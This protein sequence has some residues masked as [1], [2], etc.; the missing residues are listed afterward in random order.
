MI[1]IRGRVGD[2]PVDLEIELEAQDWMHLGAAWTSTTPDSASGPSVPEES[3]RAPARGS[4][5]LW[6]VAQG[7]VRQAGE[8]SG[9][10][11]LAELEGL[12]GSTQAAKQLLVRL[13]HSNQ[14]QLERRPEALVYRWAASPQGPE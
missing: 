12:S 1:R 9:P 2:C 10:Q 4:D 7:L 5:Q 8:M 14:V 13:R 11:L 6:S 3:D